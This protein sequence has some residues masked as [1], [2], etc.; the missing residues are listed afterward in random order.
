MSWPSVT[1]KK[2]IFSFF[3]CFEISLLVFK[4]VYTLPIENDHVFIWVAGIYPPYTF[5]RVWSKEAEM[6][7]FPNFYENF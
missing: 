4:T 2:H 3:A 1:L 6:K 7:K 5:S